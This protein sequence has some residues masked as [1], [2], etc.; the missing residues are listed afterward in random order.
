MRKDV[1]ACVRGEVCACEGEEGCVKE[2]RDVC[3]Y[4]CVCVAA[5]FILLSTTAH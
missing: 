3:M 1:Y 5:I 4:V 2:R